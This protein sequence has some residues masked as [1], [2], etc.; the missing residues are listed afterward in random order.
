MLGLYTIGDLILPNSITPPMVNT[1]RLIFVQLI[2][3]FLR[4]SVNMHISRYFRISGARL[5]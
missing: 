1:G 4:E 2:V 3:R 5:Y